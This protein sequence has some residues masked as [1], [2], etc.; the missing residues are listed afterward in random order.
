MPRGFLCQGQPCFFG[1]SRGE[2]FCEKLF[3]SLRSDPSTTNFYPGTGIHLCRNW[4]GAAL[5]RG[6]AFRV[7]LR[8]AIPCFCCVFCPNRVVSRGSLERVAGP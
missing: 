3:G 4:D 5:R 8:E 1:I 7:S 6:A 2:I